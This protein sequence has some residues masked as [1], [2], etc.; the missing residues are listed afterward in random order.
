[1]GMWLAAVGA[2]EFHMRHAFVMVLS[3][4]VMGLATLTAQSGAPSRTD[5]HVLTT[6][7]ISAAVT[8]GG[9]ALPA[10]TYELR[11]TGE[12]PATLAGQPQNSQEWVEFVSGGRVVAREAA[13]ILYDDDL[14]ATGDVSQR[15]KNGTRVE[16]LKDGEFLRISVKQERERYLIYLPVKK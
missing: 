11:L 1:M 12:H 6:V 14:E 8:A 3:A 15:V 10:G 7:R 2:Q 13:E 5:A 4:S 16:M 9:T